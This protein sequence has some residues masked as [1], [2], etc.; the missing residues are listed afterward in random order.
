MK[1][2]SADNPDP[3]NRDLS[4]IMGLGESSIR[5]NYYPSLRKTNMELLQFQKIIDRIPEGICIFDAD[6]ILTYINARVSRYYPAAEPAMMGKPFAD[7]FPELVFPLKKEQKEFHVISPG[8]SEST[9]EYRLTEITLDRRRFFVLMLRDITHRVAIEREITELNRELEQKVRRR[10]EELERSFADLHEAERKLMAT[11][12]LAS[13]GKMIST[14]AHEINTPLGNQITLATTILN[15]IDGL[16][17]AIASKE[18]T[19]EK[20]YAALGRMKDNTDLI[21]SSIGRTE[22]LVNALK[23]ATRSESVPTSGDLNLNALIETVFIQIRSQFNDQ[24]VAL[25]LPDTITIHSAASLWTEIFECLMINSF[26]YGFTAG[27][28]DYQIE[29]DVSLADGVLRIEYHD[30]GMLISPEAVR[31]FF[32]PFYTTKRNLGHFGVGLYNVFNIVSYE[33]SGTISAEPR[34]PRGLTISMTVPIKNHPGV[35]GVEGA[36]PTDK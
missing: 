22:R 6:Y 34:L 25:R 28:E 9:I 26:E 30:N 20:F 7:L 35:P 5:K 13:L 10:T 36:N 24:P 14:V 29:I 19:Q 16:H 12:R 8:D 23:T 33:L 11:Q 32:D 21:L 18:L 27:R 15:L 3:V 1:S 2:P 31:N 4:K 17:D